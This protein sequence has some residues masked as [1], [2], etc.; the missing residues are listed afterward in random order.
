MSKRFPV[1]REFANTK[2]KLSVVYRGKTGHRLFEMSP[3]TAGFIVGGLALVA[4]ISLGASL[5]VLSKDS[6]LQTVMNGQARM[7]YAY[8]DRISQL[9]AHID[10]MA[11]RQLVDQDTVET[12]LQSL[13]SRQ[14]QLESRQALV[15]RV[16]DDAAR[17]GI[18]YSARTGSPADL[19]TTG[20]VAGA[21]KS[22]PSGAQGFMAAPAKPLPDG[23][24]GGRPEPLDGLRTDRLSELGGPITRQAIPMLLDRAETVARTAADQQL[25]T[26]QA[27]E[28]KAQASV[29]TFR[30][31]LDST[32]LERE[33]FAKVMQKPAT[34]GI[35]GPLIPMTGTG[36]AAFEKA[37]TATQTY[38][39][40]TEGLSRVVRALPVR[41]PLPKTN[42]T[43]SPFGGRVD[44]FTRGMAMHS[45]QDFRASS[46]TPVKV[47]ADGK[48][49]QAD[50]V[51]GYGRLVE[52]D[53]GFGLST[54]YAHMSGFNVSVGDVVTKG[55][56]VGYVGSTGRSTGPHL[57]YEVRIDEEAVD[58]MA[59][60]RAGEKTGVE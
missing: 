30:T 2:A 20:S 23:I 44:P 41:R 56:T 59:F 28:M 38:L 22:L 54:R 37:L 6:L 47:T 50:W 34:V 3:G 48:V 19:T 14:V 27:I 58:P 32:G 1:P 9:R 46:G 25:A 35:G 53:H 26:L 17:A 5:Y 4:T 21:P 15:S 16:V 31:M 8:E 13:L 45:G 33:R 18:R 49:I 55:M 12:R 36:A 51:G 60:L 7:Q 11:G 10:R 57:H 52:V 24:S 43:S 40:E 39:R 29:K 42:E